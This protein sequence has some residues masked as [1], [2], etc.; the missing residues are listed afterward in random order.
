MIYIYALFVLF[1]S[2]LTHLLNT[3]VLNTT[4]FNF[5]YDIS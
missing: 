5:L 2:K 3:Q 4:I 1:V